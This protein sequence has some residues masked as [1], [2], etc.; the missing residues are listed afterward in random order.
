MNRRAI[1]PSVLVISHIVYEHAPTNPGVAQM[2]PRS[3]TIAADLKRVIRLAGRE[4]EAL[5]GSLPAL[6]ALHRVRS[7]GPL[8]ESARVHFI[9]HRL[10][11][12]YL[13]R[14]PS[15]RDCRAICELMAW[16]AADGQ[17]QSLTTRYH[18]AAAHL[19]NPSDDFG[20]RQEPRLLLECARRFVAFDHE[21]R[22]DSPTRTAI[23][24]EAGAGPPNRGLDPG[25]AEIATATGAPALDCHMG[26]VAGVHR[27]LDYHRLADDMAAAA[28]IVI[29]STWIPGLDIIGGAIGSALGRGA[30]ASVLMLHPD[31][32]VAQLRTR[33][34]QGSPQR[35]FR[36]DRVRPGVHHC[37]DVLAALANA[38]DPGLRRN[39]HVRL[40]D[41]LP[42]ISVYGIDDTALVSFYVHGQPA[43]STPYLEIRGGETTMGDLVAREVSALWA[44]GEEFDNVLRW[45]SEI[46]RMAAPEQAGPRL[47]N[48]TRA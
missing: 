3:R 20:R 12:E 19:V 9:L 32:P 18:K 11:P 48:A 38:L 39:L 17:I 40:Y 30:R 5:E 21:D 46:E 15:G 16:E 2:G 29:V 23:V 44:L 7:A 47:A 6:C 8:G 28:E 41:S 33:P 13:R 43:V 45:R 42:S 31:S 35:R 22:L 25:D 27:R 26:G 34:L 14:L 24:D 1:K 10:I 4:P 37:L 36:Q